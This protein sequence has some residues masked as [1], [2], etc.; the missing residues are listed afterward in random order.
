[1][2]HPPPPRAQR[3]EHDLALE[4]EL[5]ELEEEGVH[6]AA[7]LQVMHPFTPHV[8]DDTQA[9][10]WRLPAIPA[11]L[12][13]ELDAYHKWRA[14]PLN[15]CRDGSAVVDVTVGNDR[16]STLRFLGWLHAQKQILPGLGAF[17]KT[18]LG[19]WVEEWLQVLRDKGLKYSSLANYANSLIAVAGHVYAV[20]DIDE[21]IR[22]M[23]RTPLD[24]LVRLRA[25]CES[26]AKQ[27]RLFQRRDP[28]WLEWPQAQEARVK[29]ER[30]YRAKKTAQL[31]R[32][33]LIIALHTVMP[34][35]RGTLVQDS[36]CAQHMLSSAR[37]VRP[38]AVGVIRKLRQG[39]TLK[40]CG[41]GFVLDLTAQRSHKVSPPPS[42]P[43]SPPT[44]PTPVA[45]HIPTSDL[46]PDATTRVTTP[47][48]A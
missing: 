4:A 28:N 42:P 33:W 14:M 17:G 20:Y 46:T 2:S 32:D 5:E 27:Q 43:P 47:I 7:E 44:S 19:A 36:E 21:A 11:A 45:T 29:A 48:A 22:T 12:T 13:R 8:E 9:A 6:M 23:P 31:Q 35:D 1:M 37:V 30:A 10:S 15:R 40:R 16:A 26:E 18:E 41:E 38:S 34:P 39:I 24:D 25:Q 3:L